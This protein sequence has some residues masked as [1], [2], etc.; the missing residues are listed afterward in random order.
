MDRPPTVVGTAIRLADLLDWVGSPERGG[1]AAF[2]GT[3]R[4]SEHDG[5]VESI[6][7][8]AYEEMVQ[9]EAGRIIGEAQA[10][11]ENCRVHVQH[12]LGRIVLG[13][14]SIAVVAATPHRAAAFAAGSR[15]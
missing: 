7:Y 1:T 6:E 15:R 2:V 10:R 8:S 9:A 14:P 4:R 13:E 3:V 5:S 11:W 12:L